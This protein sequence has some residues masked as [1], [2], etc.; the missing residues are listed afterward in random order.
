MSEKKLDA[1]PRCNGTK[2]FNKKHCKFCKG[3]GAV[4][5]R[6]PQFAT[7]TH[8]AERAIDIHGRVIQR[9]C[10]CG[11]KL[12]D[13][14]VKDQPVEKGGR[15]KPIFTWSPGDQV[16]VSLGGDQAEKAL[17]KPTLV[18]HMNT[19]ALPADFCWGLAEQG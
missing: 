19:D 7:A 9:C 1:C 18:G 13:A 10:W 17:G 11:F 12:I 3:A 2:R 14:M 4:E 15:P 5:E 6:N 16:R 8:I